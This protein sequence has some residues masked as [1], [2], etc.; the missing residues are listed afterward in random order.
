MSKN[1]YSQT[2]TCE[3]GKRFIIDVDF[4][5]ETVDIIEKEEIF[6]EE[7]ELVDNDNI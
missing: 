2:I 1:I 6:D 5:D 4:T 3:C 7:D